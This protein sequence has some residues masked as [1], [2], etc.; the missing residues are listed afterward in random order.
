MRNAWGV[1]VGGAVPRAH[2]L[3]IEC[4]CLILAPKVQWDCHTSQVWDSETG[5]EQSAGRKWSGLLLLLFSVSLSGAR[6]GGTPEG[7]SGTWQLKAELSCS[8]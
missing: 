1:G 5:C 6:G 4:C 8:L 3:L 7:R 2:R